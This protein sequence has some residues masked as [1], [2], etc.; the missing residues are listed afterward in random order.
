MSFIERRKNKRVADVLG[1]RVEQDQVAEHSDITGTYV[2]NLSVAGLGFTSKTPLQTDTSVRLTLQLASQSVPV[3]LNA[4]V[5]SCAKY[6]STDSGNQY[7]MRIIFSELS[8][9]S[10]TILEN[11]INQIINLTTVIK[12]LPYRQ[13]A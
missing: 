6:T 7:K 9:T 5:V 2:A 12:E 8:N 11:H 3:R 13:I 10:R 1:L 4:R